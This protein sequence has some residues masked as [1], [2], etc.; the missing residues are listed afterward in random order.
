MVSW[1]APTL[2]SAPT[3]HIV[4]LRPE[5]GDAGSGKTKRPKAKKTSLTYDK[6]E[7]DPLADA[8]CYIAAP[9]PA[10]SSWVEETARAEGVN[11]GRIND[12]VAE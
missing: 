9:T 8:A 6:V 10:G 4:Q 5:G 11:L 1:T 12:G 7:A 3:R 2:G